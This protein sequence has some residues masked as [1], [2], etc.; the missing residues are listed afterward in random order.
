MDFKKWI[1]G[2]FSLVTGSIAA[3]WLGLNP[4][5]QLLLI[6]IVLDVLSGLI[7]AFMKK[8]IS[9]TVSWAGLG[10][11]AIILVIV[12]GAE[13]AGSLAEIQINETLT[14]GAMVAGFYA[15]NEFI[16]ILENAA[17]A[18][19]PIPKFL[20]DALQKLNSEKFESPVPP[21][22]DSYPPRAQG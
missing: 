15:V 19:I 8:E 9:S 20:K 16:S 2:A 13:F 4:L 12:A 5:M 11:K 21:G 22:G 1:A 3:Y 14:L 7:G 10:K 18:G 6:L 17:A